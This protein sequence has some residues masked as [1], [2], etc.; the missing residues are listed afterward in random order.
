MFS[1]SENAS[2]RE[3]TPAMKNRLSARSFGEYSWAFCSVYTLATLCYLALPW[4]GYVFSALVFL[5]AIVLA[6]LRWQRGPVLVMATLSALLWNFLFIPPKF[7]LH[8]EKPEDAIMFGM[9]FL[10]ALSMGHL[11]SRLHEREQSLERQKS[12]KQALLEVLQ[13]SV[14]SLDV[15]GEFD[16]AVDAMKN[17]IGADLAVFLRKD[18]REAALTPHTSSRFCP[19]PEEW[20]AVHWCAEHGKPAGR[21]MEKFPELETSWLPIESQKGRI[22]V[23]GFC[24]QEEISPDFSTHRMMEALTL[25]LALIIERQHVLETERKAE[26]V[27][28]SER[29][30]RILFDSVSHELKT[31]IAVIRTALDGLNA[32][33]PFVT[34]IETATQRLQRIVEHF[35]EISRLE[36]E[37]LTPLHDW[38]DIPDLLENS[39]RILGPEWP[40]S[41]SVRSEV[42]SLP[43]IKVDGRLLAQ[44]LANIIHN[45]AVHA[46]TNIPITLQIGLEQCVLSISVQDQGPG[47]VPGSES[48]IFDKFY[49]APGTRAGG[50]GL[51]LAIARGFIR[52]QGGDI[53]AR[54]RPEGGAEFQIRLPVEIHQVADEETHEHGAHH[55]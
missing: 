1:D 22:G 44:A 37:H 36:S 45:A 50:T 4:T 26:L 19:T 20:T 5:L 38:I 9:F 2:P 54:N 13:K 39:K 14:L 11:T 3:S 23:V 15:S 40:S 17:I 55:R 52:A 28:Q 47:I 34:E 29:L 25:Q 16:A 6:A 51:G 12:E 41:V 43:L 42:L 49:R 35:L 7:T 27:L 32:R 46:G 10:V 53:L 31:P 18:L 24:W 33:D 48:L 8:I 21:H 30:H